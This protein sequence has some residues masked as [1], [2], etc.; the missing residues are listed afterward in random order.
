MNATR[1]LA[2]AL[3]VSLLPLVAVARPGGGGFSR[4]SGGFDMHNDA[5]WSRSRSSTGS[6]PYGSHTSSWSASTNG[7]YSH[8]GSGSNAY[9]SYAT[10][11][12][13]NVHDGTNYHATTATNA[14]GQT[15]HG[16]S[17][18]SNGYV[19]HGAV[20]TNPVYGGYNAWGWNS[21]VAWYPAPMYWGGGFW[22]PYAVGAAAAYGSYINA[23]NQN[24]YSYQLQPDS[25]GAKLLASYNLTQT[26]CGPPNLVVI[27]GPNGSA[28]CAQPNN[29][30]SAGNYSVDST[31]LTI[32]SEKPS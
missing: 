15:Y 11:G 16:S 18:A 9:G 19:Y 20:V 29:L 24:V 21:G 30:V 27:Y 22:G 3:V 25:P 7:T 26:P 8:T 10:A 32:V 31:K 2:C 28:I 17:Y 13:G 1:F 6:T 14:Y 23:A 5:P 12:G 4:P